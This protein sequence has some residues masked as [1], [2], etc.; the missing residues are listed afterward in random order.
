MV[1]GSAVRKSTGI[2]TESPSLCRGEKEEMEDAYRYTVLFSWCSR[3]R[4]WWTVKLSRAVCSS[5]LRHGL[6]LVRRAAEFAVSEKHMEG[7][8]RCE[9]CYVD[10]S[11][12]IPEPR[13]SCPSIMLIADL[14]L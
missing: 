3:S 9:E 7:L 6:L 12:E 11:N 5:R 10:E 4:E 13:R 1:M 8:H 14:K 2:C